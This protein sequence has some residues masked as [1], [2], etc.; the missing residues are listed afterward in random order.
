M[1]QTYIKNFTQA[2]RYEYASSGVTIQHLAPMFVATKMNHFSEKIY[3]KSFFVPD[4]RSYSKYAV[5]MLGKLDDSSGYWTH[6]LQVI[7]EFWNS[8][9]KKV[10][11]ISL[12]IKHF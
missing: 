4:P 11:L 12:R 3:R 9:D 10:K 2:L 1:L 7:W 6:G 5:S 8:L